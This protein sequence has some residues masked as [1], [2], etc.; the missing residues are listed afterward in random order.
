MDRLA[1]EGVKLENYFTY[2][3]CIP[4]RGALLTGRYPIRLGLWQSYGG[5]ELPLNETTLAQEM[6]SAG[7]RTYMVGKWH[8][9]FST[10]EHT[11]TYRG[12]D[13]SY[14]YW[15]GFVDYWTK[16]YGEYHDLHNG[17]ELITDLAEL[18]TEL[19]NGYLMQTKAEKAIQNH[20]ENYSNQ[21]MFLYYP[22]QLIHGVW[23]APESFLERCGMPSTISD[24][25][26]RNITYNYCALNVMLDEAIANLT[27]TLKLHGMAENTVLVV[28][29]DNGG[30]SS[31]NGN[32]F[33]FRGNKGSLFRGG[34][35]G[36][37]FVHS[38]LLPEAARGQAYEGQMHVTD[39]LPTLMGLATNNQWTG[40]LFG[41]V[42]DGVDQW[43]ALTTPG[44]ASPRTEIVHFHDGFISSSVQI[45]MIKL[46]CSVEVKYV[47]EPD[48]VFRK[49]HFPAY[50]TF[51]CAD[52]SIMR[53]VITYMA[54]TALSFP[55]GETAI[56]TKSVVIAMICLLVTL[57]LI[58]SV[59]LMT[60]MGKT[61][62]NSIRSNPRDF[63]AKQC[64]EGQIDEST[65]L[66]S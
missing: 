47:S 19:H 10:P 17:T 43:A 56:F 55:V 50:S 62:S 5:T 46:D 27:C 22:M 39:W 37:G 31:V 12:F 26:V 32:S 48:F 35:S 58:M 13:S 6:Q 28:V 52:P 16:S 63:K 34:L 51:L 53:D 11:P 25:S 57:V 15:N 59:R 40:S 3:T 66:L 38:Q 18:S 9:G 2:Y 8:L 20:V 14:S 60:I 21:P 33:P 44:T 24:E 7:Y 45:N 61:E 64:D 4:S 54:A 36:T 42:L 65:R 23:S 30:E 49:D 41:A 29:S 1:A